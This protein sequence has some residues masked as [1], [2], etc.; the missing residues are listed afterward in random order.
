MGAVILKAV[1][2]FREAFPYAPRENVS[3]FVKKHPAVEFGGGVGSA[4]EV[5]DKLK[6]K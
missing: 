1:S 5:P 6:Y 4:Y 3:R 2:Q